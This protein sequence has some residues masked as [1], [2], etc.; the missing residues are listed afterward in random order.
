VFAPFVSVNVK[1]AGS[2]LGSLFFFS[3]QIP[4]RGPNNKQSNLRQY[5][6]R[7]E[8]TDTAAGEIIINNRYI[9]PT[10]TPADFAVSVS[11]NRKNHCIMRVEQLLKVIF[12]SHFFK[13]CASAAKRLM[14]WKNTPETVCPFLRT[15]EAFLKLY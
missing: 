2:R 3:E 1:S 5:Q 4:Q 8:Q 11:K 6:S 9:T 12:S 13:H 7:P 14:F 10:Q 15:L